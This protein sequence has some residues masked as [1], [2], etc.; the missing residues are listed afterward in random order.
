MDPLYADAHDLAGKIYAKQKEYQ[1]AF[2]HF[3]IALSAGSKTKDRRHNLALAYLDLKEYKG[4][5]GQY[6]GIVKVWPKDPKGHFFLAKAYLLDGQFAPALEALKKAHQLS[7]EDIRDLMDLG[8]LF[9]EK[10]AY[11]EAQAVYTM[12][13]ATGKELVT[14]HKKLGKAALGLNDRPRA[15]KAFQDALSIAPEDEEAKAALMNL[16]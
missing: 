3:R 10:Q 8:D 13:L 16:R 1:K 2:E 15:I 11:P 6:Q 5:V 4:A 14:V 9:L 7:P 12:G